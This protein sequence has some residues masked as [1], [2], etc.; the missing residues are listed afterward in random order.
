[1]INIWGYH[2]ALN[3]GF[4][5]LKDKQLSRIISLGYFQVFFQHFH[6]MSSFSFCVFVAIKSRGNEICIC[7]FDDGI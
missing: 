7:K 1:V 5:S 2:H 6:S 4:V 3:L